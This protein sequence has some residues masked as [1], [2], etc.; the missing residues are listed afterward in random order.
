MISTEGLIL[1]KHKSSFKHK[2]NKKQTKLLE[3]GQRL[4]IKDLPRNVIFWVIT[5]ISQSGKEIS[6]VIDSSETMS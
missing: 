5:V 1:N 3:K 2:Q 6:L 4:G